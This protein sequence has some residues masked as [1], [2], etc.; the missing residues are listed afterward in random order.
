M[1][2]ENIS[3]WSVDRLKKIFVRPALPTNR[4]QHT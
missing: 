4:D 3:P 1:P 2:F